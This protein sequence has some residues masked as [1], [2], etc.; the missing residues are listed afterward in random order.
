MFAGDELSEDLSFEKLVEECIRHVQILLPH[1]P[2]LVIT[3]G[4]HGV[5]IARQSDANTP[6]PIRS[7]RVSNCLKTGFWIN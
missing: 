7:S 2:N 6:F 5:I 1:I 4:K 3:L